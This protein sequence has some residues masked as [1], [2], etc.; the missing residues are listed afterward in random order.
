MSPSA[1]S[2]V[3]TSSSLLATTPS[4]VPSHP[5]ISSSSSSSSS[6][7]SPMPT[8]NSSSSKDF[9]STIGWDPNAYLLSSTV[10]QPSVLSPA[11]PGPVQRPQASFSPAPGT[12]NHTTSRCIQRPSPEPRSSSSTSAAPFP[13]YFPMNYAGT[14]KSSAWNEATV[15][16][17]AHEPQW[18]YPQEAQ[19]AFGLASDATDFPLYDPFH[20]GA[21]LPRPPSSLLTNGFAGRFSRPPLVL[22][23]FFTRSI[24]HFPDLY[25][26]PHENDVNDMDALDKEIEDFKK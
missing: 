25:A 1:A 5:V 6:L 10:L 18:T 16:T 24:E 8:G 17:V 2:S 13:L 22:F 23:D 12:L 21:G 19:Q 7:L 11:A 26:V 14:S 20:S 15:A 4:Y 3:L 9:S